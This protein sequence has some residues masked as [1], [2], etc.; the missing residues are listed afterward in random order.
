MDA[1]FP[2]YGGIQLHTF[3]SSALPCQTPFCQTAPV[4][5]SLTRQHH[6]M[7]CWWEGLPSTAIQ[8]TSTSD[9]VGQHNKIGGVTSGATLVF[10]KCLVLKDIGSIILF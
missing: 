3:A 4:L 5:P 1:I 6:V 7:E 8:P 10:E 9:I 2:P